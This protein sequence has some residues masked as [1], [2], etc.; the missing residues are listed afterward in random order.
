MMKKTTLKKS[1]G[2]Y[3]WTQT[4]DSITVSLPVRNVALKNIHVQWTDLCLK[5]NVPSIRYI[6]VVDFP[7][8]VDFTDPKNRVQ[9]LD[10]SLDVFLIK[11]DLN[12]E[13]WPEVQLTGLS[14]KELTERRNESIRRYDEYQS[15]RAAETTSLTW[16]LDR[17]ATTQQMAVETHSR[18]F[19]ENSK[20]EMHRTAQDELQVELDRMEGDNQRLTREKR[21]APLAPPRA[22]PKE[23]RASKFKRQLN[24]DIF[25]AGDVIAAPKRPKVAEIEEIETPAVRES[26]RTG[27]EKTEV[28]AEEEEEEEEE[29]Q[30][31][32]V[33]EDQPEAEVPDVRGKKEPVKMPFTEKTFAHLPARESQLKEP[34]YPRSK[35]LTKQPNEAGLD[36]EDKDPVWLKDKGDMF[37]KRHDFTA[38]IAAYAKAL[39]AD[40]DFLMGKLNRATCFIMV[41][42]FSAGA[43]DCDDIVRQIEALKPEEFESDKAF[44]NKVKARALVKRGAAN[45]WMSNFD[46]AVADFTKVLAAEELHQHLGPHG[47]ASL[48][49]DL[50]VVT[51]RQA[52]QAVKHKGDALFYQEKY[53]QAVE[54]YEEALEVDKENEYAIA[55]IGVVHLKRQEHAKCVECSTRALQLIDNFQSDT[56]PFSRVNVLEVKLLLRRARSHQALEDYEAAKVDLDKILILEPQNGEASGLLKTVQ[57]KLDGVTF[58]KYR[59]EANKL[60]QQREFQAALDAYDRALKVTRKATTLDNIAVYVN[61]I[62]CLLSLDKLD[63]VVSECNEAIRLIRNYKNRFTKIPPGDMERLKQMD[64]RVA[65]RRGNAL[66]KLARV[67]EAVAEYERALKIDPNNAAIKKDLDLLRKAK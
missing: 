63:R 48:T 33:E 22:V 15:K 35:K 43:E 50:A 2:A 25:G 64:L 1:A 36:V 19:L 21:A 27:D 56:K 40:P 30:V 58:T 44:Y 12:T 10:S 55:N 4:K 32:E 67:S 66:G 5:V 8:P 14:G 57:S 7:F 59:E 61:K 45:A 41:R 26:S 54:K 17:L 62:A 37:F 42:A 11:K 51:N 29:P 60:L 34:P 39:K 31:Y 65:V 23:E 46:E 20:A 24:E 53:D 38:A 52:S 6:Q 49:R 47:V 28:P 3:S 16:E 13:L 18:D 9:L